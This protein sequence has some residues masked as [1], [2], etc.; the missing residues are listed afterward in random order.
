MGAWR[1][2][3]VMLPLA[4]VAL[5]GC[6]LPGKPSAEPEFPRPEQVM[7][8]DKLYGSN[9]AGCHG[10]NGQGGGAMNLA[11]P[12]YQALVDDATLRD[13]ISN[14]EAGTLMPAFSTKRGGQLTEQQIDALIAGMRAQW[15]R[16]DVLEGQDA[17]PYKAAHPG[18]VAK[19]AV[20]YQTACA[21][22]H[23]AQP[24]KPAEGGSIRDGS[25][26][27]LVN[28]QMIR[29]TVIAGRPDLGMPDW[30]KQVNGRALT[31]DEIA[32]VTAWLM[33]QRPVLPGQPY[34]GRE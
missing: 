9:C 15:S 3:A 6:R 26:L 21:S 31:N 7:S 27:A 1:R 4:L 14:G 30:R 18:D 10:A 2:V 16:G 22:C 12:V 19:G 17:P 34:G 33:S 29:T 24:G 5:A 32:D 13:V 23:E 28:E 20:A 8:F 11:N 25:F